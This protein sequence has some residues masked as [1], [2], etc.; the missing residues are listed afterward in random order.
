MNTRLMAKASVIAIAAGI[1]MPQMASAQSAVDV[2]TDQIFV[3]GTKK[4]NA[5]NVQEVPL[6]VTAYGADQ[7]DALKVRDLG[8]LSYS[9]P[10]VGLED[11]GTARGVAN[12]SIRGLGVNSSIPSI[13][14]AVATFVDGV[15]LGQN[16]G[17]VLDIFDL[18][19]IEVLRGP[20]GILFGRNVTGGAV[21]INTKR[22]SMDD[23][24]VS[25]KGTL[26][27]GLRGTGNNYYLMGSISGPIFQDTLAFKMS[28]YYNN[29]RGYHKRYLPQTNQEAFLDLVGGTLSGLDTAGFPIATDGPGGTANH[30]KAKTYIFRPSLLWQ[31][32][33][34]FE[35]LIRYERFHS[36]G[37]GPS[38]Q[39]HPRMLEAFQ[40]V[41]G[42]YFGPR[43]Q[44]NGLF[45][46]P[47]DS[48][49]FS[50]DEPGRYEQVVNSITVESNLDVGFGDGV[51][52]N[53]FG[54]RDSRGTSFGDIDGTP[55]FLFHSGADN[56]L[57]QLSNE[58][59]YSGRFWDRMDLTTGFYYYDADHKYQEERFILGNFRTLFGGGLQQSR[60]Y[61]IFGQ[62]DYDL[63]DNFTVIAGGRYTNE[64]KAAQISNITLGGIPCNVIIGTCTVHFTDENTWKYFTPKV[65]FKWAWNDWFNTYGHWSQGVRS[66]GYNFRNTS[67]VF[68]IARFEEETVNSF[69]VGFKAQP[70]DGRAQINAAFFMN[71]VNDMQREINLPDPIAGVVQ[72]IN[73][74][75]DATI[76]GIEIEAQYALTDN[77]LLMANL[78]RLD[79]EYDSVALNISSDFIDADGD[80]L[81]DAGEVGILDGRDLQLGIPRLSPW[82]YG[83]G[84]IHSLDLGNFAEVATRFNW[85][86]REDTPY[87]D[88]NLGVLQ[89][90]DIIDF[91]VALNFSEGATFSLY[92]RNML[93]EVTHGGETQ[94]PLTIAG[95]TFAPLNKGRRVGVEL[96]L[97]F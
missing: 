81:I 28:A 65:G 58:I 18:E 83:L 46:A 21:L 42:T 17:V 52:T 41:G 60:N 72:L 11:I 75:A 85:A 29:D 87:T 39:N 31:P 33:E 3:T 73:N 74:T 68:P 84:F 36:E 59:R 89:G 35:T 43:P 96:Q 8:S 95:G 15:Y 90:A 54:W 61:G 88:N 76:F 20:Q 40:S 34:T 16:A 14:P 92:G 48:F 4:A 47:K 24:E 2:L 69:E 78:G 32:S 26:E 30:G 79:G 64:K 10:N 82:T 67:I 27:N 25:F 66:G 55:F 44:S 56:R 37:D 62:I 77:I 97:D 12:F 22:P 71:D 49:I 57:E 80:T 9:V 38:A 50:I 6:A 51:I 1:C 19:S 93:D 94:L 23:V 91:S 13:D 53:I 70:A 63:T 45:S 5:E 7:L 86:H